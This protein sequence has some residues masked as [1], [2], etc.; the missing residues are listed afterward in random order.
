MT[1]SRKASGLSPRSAVTFAQGPLFFGRSSAASSASPS[2][3]SSI[4]P[5]SSCMFAMASFT[6]DA[7]CAG[8]TR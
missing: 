2:P 4:T 6:N 5:S 3:S 7:T 8:S 1:C